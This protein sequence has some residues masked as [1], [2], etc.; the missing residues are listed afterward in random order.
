MRDERL[1]D[2][3]R[4][5]LTYSLELKRGELFQINSGIGAKPLI[6]ALMIEANKVGAVPLLKLEDDELSRLSFEF[7]DPEHPEFAKEVLAKYVQWEMAYW[8]HVAAHVD[9][10]VDE[11]DMELA[12]VDPR[13]IQLR[14]T[15]T[16]SVKDL[17]I[18][19][20][21][22][23]YLCWPTM[24][25][26]QK[27]GMCYDDYYEFFIDVCLVDYQKMAKDLEPLRELM[28][29]TDRVRI[30]GPDTDLEFSIKGIPVRP[31]AGKANIP[32]GEIYTAP[33]RDSINGTI[34]YNTA[35]N[36]LG[37]EY[38]NVRF[39]FRDG[40]IIE[41]TAD[42][43]ADALSR[44]LDT[45]EGARYIGEFALGVN[46]RITKALGNTLYDEKIGGSFHLTPGNAY[47]DAFN[48]NKSA[49]HW[50]IVC[51]QTK[52]YG[53][54]TIYFDGEPIREDGI[55]LPAA[56]QGLNP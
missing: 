56:L 32:D 3:A 24:A 52:E 28:A 31:C 35:T 27:A 37:H 42:N 15:A 4:M 48:G 19:Q 46:N 40:C 14:R 22:W 6:K 11:N 44:L 10:G 20:R 47:Q 1:F 25:Q 2:L 36:Y 30:T 21:K 29:K 41:A 8:E 17:T 43:D 23:V 49:I 7:I 34:R 12:G 39:E 18:D 50:D 16:K 5:L 9:I 53:G 55:F 45:D 26:A 38:R 54:G 13:K 33:V 51:I